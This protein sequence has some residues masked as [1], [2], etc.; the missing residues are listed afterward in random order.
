MARSR[1]SRLLMAAA[2]CSIATVAGCGGTT[3]AGVMT[4]RTA[5]SD[6]RAAYIARADEICKSYPNLGRTT[7]RQ[8]TRVRTHRNSKPKL[9]RNW[10]KARQAAKPQTTLRSQLTPSGMLP[11]NIAP[12]AG[13]SQRY[14]PLPGT[15]PSSSGSI[16][17]T[18]SRPQT[19][20]ARRTLTNATTTRA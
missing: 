20:N 1:A 19:L 7:H 12:S 10:K 14:L 17:S 5:A 8:K 13:C 18:M 6:A 3:T 2:S 9:A 15:G 4:K 11:R 16:D